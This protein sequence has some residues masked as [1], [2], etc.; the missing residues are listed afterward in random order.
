M[1]KKSF[2]LGL[3]LIF[4]FLASGCTL[5]KGVGGLAAGACEGA[6]EDWNA[7]KKADVWVKDN[8]W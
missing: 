1:I 7:L 5:A 8:L 2:L 4:T 6:K 3:L